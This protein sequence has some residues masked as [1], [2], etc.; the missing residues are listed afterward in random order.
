MHFALPSLLIAVAAVA[1]V[2]DLRTGAIRNTLTYGVALVALGLHAASGPA[3]A[4][5]SLACMFAV[6]V[7]CLPIFSFGWLRGGDVKMVVA[8][9]GLVSLPYL[10]P[11]LLY[12]ML[13]GG[14]VSLAVAWRYGTLRASLQSVGSVAHPLLQGVVPTSLPF[15]SRKIP[16]GVA[17]FLGSVLT[18]LAMTAVPALR[19][20]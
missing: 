9:S 6:L 20:A 1:A 14:L 11:F 13:C 3:P 8:C 10:L 2:S 19:L 15:T 5:V 4:F 17:I 12:T 7:A 16:Y 18:A